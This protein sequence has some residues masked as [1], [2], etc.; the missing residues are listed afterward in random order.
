MDDGPASHFSQDGDGIE[1]HQQVQQQ[2]HQQVQQQ[3]P[4]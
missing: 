3:H 2:N 1:L 4:M